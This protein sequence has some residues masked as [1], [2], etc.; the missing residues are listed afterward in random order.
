MLVDLDYQA[1]KISRFASGEELEMS[2]R[3]LFQCVECHRT[4]PLPA[5]F[6]CNSC[7]AIVCESDR[8]RHKCQKPSQG[9]EEAESHWTEDSEETEDAEEG[10]FED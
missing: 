4:F 5:L 9:T 1:G 3:G 7:R 8:A 6:Q 10:D 2:T